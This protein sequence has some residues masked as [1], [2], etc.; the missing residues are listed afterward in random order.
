MVYSP[1]GTQIASGSGGYDKTVRLWEVSSGV[2]LRVIH[3]FRWYVYSVA[4]TERDGHQYLVSGSGD[5]SVRQWE[6]QKEAEGYK[7]KLNWSSGHGALSVADM[8]LEGVEGLSEMNG[9]LLRQRGAL[10]SR[11]RRAVGE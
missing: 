2:C 6:L 1:S 7:L 11:G 9:R 5:R 10:E 3:E 4:W 8:L